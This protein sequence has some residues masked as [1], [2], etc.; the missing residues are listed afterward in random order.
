MHA[1]ELAKEI[2]DA[3]ERSGKKQI[4]VGN[5]L[6]VSSTT[7]SRWASGEIVL[8]VARAA[9]LAAEIG[10]D[11]DELER[12]AREAFKEKREGKTST[13]VLGEVI[14][15]RFEALETENALLIR[16]VGALESRLEALQNDLDSHTHTHT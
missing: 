2:R 4:S 12:L 16:R 8:P 1:R 5:A 9:E 15:E 13:E 11:P 7:V 14:R 6:G 10:L 3:L